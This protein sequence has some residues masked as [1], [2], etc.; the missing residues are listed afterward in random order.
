MTAPHWDAVFFDLDGTLADT[1]PLILACYRHTMRTVRGRALP[2]R[3]WLEQVGR[4]LR[5]SFL[6]FTDDPEE[7]RLFQETY[8]AHQRSI[9]DEMVRPLPG[10]VEVVGELADLGVPLGVVTSKRREMALRTLRVCGLDG[11]FGIV[12]T[13]DDV[14]KGKPDP[15]PVRRALEA[16]PAARAGD[17]VFVGDSPYD[18]AAGRAAGVRTVAVTTGPFDGA[19]LAREEPDF[20]VAALSDSRWRS[21]S[22]PPGPYPFP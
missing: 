1:V 8:V 14:V 7:A 13:A 2:D 22:S 18:V 10:A 6:E 21:R 16:F 5:D 9:H 12:V 4:P 11:A 20:L 19:R 17:A 3:L 15:E